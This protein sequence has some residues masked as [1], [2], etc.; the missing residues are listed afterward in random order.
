MS[1]KKTGKKEKI[2]ESFAAPEKGKDIRRTE[3]FEVH[4]SI[5]HNKY[6]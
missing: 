2:N 6:T 3:L 1:P 5:P 4:I